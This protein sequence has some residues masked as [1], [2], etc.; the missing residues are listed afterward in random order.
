MAFFLSV[1]TAFCYFFGALNSA[2]N[3]TSRYFFSDM[4][5]KQNDEE[6][7]IRPCGSVIAFVRGSSQT[8][9]SRSDIWTPL[10]KH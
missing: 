4:K 8:S 2:V 7:S 10:A 5:G 6:L 3:T 9:H 1:N